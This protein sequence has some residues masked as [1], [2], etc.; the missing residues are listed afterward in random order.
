L[1]DKRFVSGAARG[2]LLAQGGK[3]FCERWLRDRVLEKLRRVFR[4]ILTLGSGP[5]TEF[6]LDFRRQGDD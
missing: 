6:G 5:L 4:E 2:E 1:R 3:Q